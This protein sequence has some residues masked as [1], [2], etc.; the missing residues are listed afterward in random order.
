MKLLLVLLALLFALPVAAQ[1]VQRDADGVIHVEP[2]RV[3]GRRQQPL[4][5]LVPRRR[6]VVGSRRGS[7]T[8][9]VRRV[10]QTVRRAPF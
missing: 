9:F 4:S 2:V 1:D 5:V 6:D 10:V 8:S 7:Q 3:E